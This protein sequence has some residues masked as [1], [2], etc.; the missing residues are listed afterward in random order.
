MGLYQITTKRGDSYKGSCYT[1]SLSNPELSAYVPVDLTDCEVLMQVKT[2]ATD[3][4]SVLEFSTS[5]ATISIS[6]PAVSGVFYTEPRIVD[7]PANKYVY[8]IQITLNTGRILTPVSDYF[9]VTQDVS[10]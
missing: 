1:I 6:T 4:H 9:N 2:K 8:D 7:V 3:D 5:T 10:R